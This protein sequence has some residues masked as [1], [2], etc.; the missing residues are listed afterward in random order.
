M[1]DLPSVMYQFNHKGV[2]LCS[3]YNGTAIDESHLDEA[4][5]HAIDSGAEDVTVRRSDPQFGTVFEFLTEPDTGSFFKVKNTLV[6][7]NYTVVYSEV[8][9]IASNPVQLGDTDL[10]AVS[11]LCDKLLNHSD[12]TKLYHNIEEAD[13]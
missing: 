6:K 8:D 4:L 11:T 12:V 3:A 7:L 13:S 5:A 1:T 10:S 2:I 9:Y